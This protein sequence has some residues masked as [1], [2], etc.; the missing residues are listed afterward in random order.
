VDYTGMVKRRYKNDLYAS[1]DSLDDVPYMSRVYGQAVS[2]M[3]PMIVVGSA[4]A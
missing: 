4:K 2:K 1:P 3:G